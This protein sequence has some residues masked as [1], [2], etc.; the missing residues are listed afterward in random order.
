M[1]KIKSERSD[2]E[3]D[4]EFDSGLNDMQKKNQINQK[5]E[6]FFYDLFAS[7]GFYSTHR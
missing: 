1:M 6:R 3:D 7:V 2:E 4:H 5:S